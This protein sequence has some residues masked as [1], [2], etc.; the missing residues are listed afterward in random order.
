MISGVAKVPDVYHGIYHGMN[1]GTAAY[2]I[3]AMVSTVLYGSWRM[4]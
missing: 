3:I 2:T 4:P 1:N